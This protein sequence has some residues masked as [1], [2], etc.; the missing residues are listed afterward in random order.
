MSTRDE[1]AN[2]IAQADS[3]EVG[4]WTPGRW[5]PCTATSPTRSSLPATTAPS[6]AKGGEY[7]VR[8]NGITYPNVFLT[9][10]EAW[11]WSEGF[12]ARSAETEVVRRLVG[13]WEVA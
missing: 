7:A 9:A 5:A 8:R 10:D 4:R 11:K 6:E 1:L 3:Q 2:L 12:T 13:P